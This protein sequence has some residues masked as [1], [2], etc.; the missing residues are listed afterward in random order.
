MRRDSQA[1]FT[2]V[3]LLVAI[4][5]IGIMVPSVVTL[6]ASLGRLNDRARDMII[7]NSLAEN[8]AEGLRSEGFTALNN[9]TVNFTNE[10]P[11]TIGSPRS[12]TYTITSPSS[13]IRQV[14][15]HITYNDHGT[16]RTLTYRTYVGELGVGQY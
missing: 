3:E 14:D 7:I 11:Q 15:M 2:I 4:A 12:A 8:K 9:S 1:G 16:T 6:T 13:S 10:L 5:V